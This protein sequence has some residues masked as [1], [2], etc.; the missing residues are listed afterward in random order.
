MT[1][2]PMLNIKLCMDF[3]EYSLDIQFIH[4]HSQSGELYFYCGVGDISLDFLDSA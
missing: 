3:T 1:Q 2:V 4:L